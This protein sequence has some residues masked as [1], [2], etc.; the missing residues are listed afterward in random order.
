M[1]VVDYDE[2]S[3][4]HVTLLR[5]QDIPRS[6]V[7]TPQLREESMMTIPRIAF[8]FT[9]SDMHIKRRQFGLIYAFCIS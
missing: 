2:Q 8:S 5:V 3:M 4:A 6:G 9:V 7:I 1:V